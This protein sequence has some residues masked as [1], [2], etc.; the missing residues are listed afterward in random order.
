MLL[1]QRN[2][3][4]LQPVSVSSTSKRYSES[5]GNETPDGKGAINALESAPALGCGARAARQ[6]LAAVRVYAAPRPFA[7]QNQAETTHVSR[8]SRYS[9][10]S[11]GSCPVF[12]G[13]SHQ[14]Q[15]QRE[16]LLVALG[17]VHGVPVADLGVALQKSEKKAPKN[18]FLESTGDKCTKRVCGT[19][20]DSTTTGASLRTHRAQRSNLLVLGRN[21]GPRVRQRGLQL[22]NLR[23]YKREKEEQREGEGER[24]RE[25]E[26]G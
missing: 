13:T 4:G 15:A 20:A 3:A 19:S 5:D 14:L 18:H 10:S 25:R 7:S 26:S 2:K 9:F 8:A 21:Q 24:E 17:E 1:L 16:G 22:C 6:R 12:R 11:I 23:L